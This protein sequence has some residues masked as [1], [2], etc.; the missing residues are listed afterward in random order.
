MADLSCLTFEQAL[1]EMET[2]I[3]LLEDGKTTL[4]QAIEAYERGAKLKN[5]CEEQLIKARTRVSKV[6][7]AREDGGIQ[8]QPLEMLPG[9]GSA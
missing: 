5:Y 8:L 6:M 4:D 2:L 7:V 1:K 9:E 3:H